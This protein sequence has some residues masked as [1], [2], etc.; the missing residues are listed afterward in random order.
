MLQFLKVFGRGVLTTVMLPFILLA[1]VLYGVYCIGVFI[2]MFF[3]GVIDYFKGNTF[4][5]ELPEDLEAR[6]MVLEKEK[7]E[8]INEP[9]DTLLFSDFA[10][11]FDKLGSNGKYD[12]SCSLTFSYDTSSSDYTV[13]RYA[14]IFQ[15]GAKGTKKTINGVEWLVFKEE[16]NEKMIDYEY[17]AKFNNHFY[18]ARYSDYGSGNLCG[19]ALETIINSFK[20]TK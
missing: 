12:D 14:A 8:T 6:R 5:P 10:Y 16:L 17:Y 18:E 11:R 9:G 19:E 20:L 2:V 4:N 13:E 7:Q 1:W 3:K 15:E